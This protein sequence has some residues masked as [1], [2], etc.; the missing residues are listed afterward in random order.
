M[1]TVNKEKASNYIAQFKGS[2]IVSCQPVDDGP[3]DKTEH[4][5]AMALA[6]IDG[7]AKG[8]R[9]EGVENVSAVAS[10][11]KGAVPIIGIVKRDL[12]ETDVRI[13]P[14]TSD[15]RELA[16]A[17]A[18]IIAFD[19]TKRERPESVSTLINEIHGL[20]CIAMADC[21][22]LIS[23]IEAAQLNCTFIGT[24]LSGYTGNSPIPE[25][26]DFELVELL[27]YRGFNVIAEGR[28][29]SPTLASRAIEV[30]AL[31]VTVGSAVT[32]I[33]HI[34]QWFHKAIDAVAREMPR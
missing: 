5:V 7:G 34:T 4:I 18:E 22:D 14:F 21:D 23:G 13:T 11:I 15:I 33:E 31:T 10:A 3:M 1:N 24:T 19:A 17:G 27:A 26:P 28:F 2:V 25:E 32:R 8:L 30:G 20:D 9:I 6:A 16:A 12:E 29:N